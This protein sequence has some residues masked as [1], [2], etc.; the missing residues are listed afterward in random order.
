M[1][2]LTFLSPYYPF[3]VIFVTITANIILLLVNSRW[4]TYLIANILLVLILEM[5]GL[6]TFDMIGLLVGGLVNVL[7]T[8]V[9]ELFGILSGCSIL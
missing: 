3:I 2:D 4:Y 7:V 5:I 1:I 9:K 6:E 8:I